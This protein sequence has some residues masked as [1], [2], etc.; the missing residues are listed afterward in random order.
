MAASN[1]IDIVHFGIHIGYSSLITRACRHGYLFQLQ[2]LLMTT[3]N[4]TILDEGG[5]ESI[6]HMAFGVACQHKQKEIVHWLINKYTSIDWE[7]KIIRFIGSLSLDTETELIYFVLDICDD[8]VMLPEKF[9]VT[10]VNILFKSYYTYKS[11]HRLAFM[12]IL[13]NMNNNVA[14]AINHTQSLNHNSN[15]DFIVYKALFNRVIV[16]DFNLLEKVCSEVKNTKFMGALE[17]LYELIYHVTHNNDFLE[18][19]DHKL[20]RNSIRDNNKLVAEWLTH[21]ISKYDIITENRQAVDFGRFVPPNLHLITTPAY[22]LLGLNRETVVTGYSI[23]NVK[24]HLNGKLYCNMYSIDFKN[25]I[26]K[27]T[28]ETCIICYDKNEEL[29]TS[30]GHSYCVDCLQ[31]WINQKN[32]SNACPYCKQNMDYF[33]KVV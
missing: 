21:K 32:K 25:E 10:V 31:T 12:Y 19:Y 8:N 16:I 3:P 27:E 13:E 26:K 2:S 18:F 15:L 33:V 30:C 17:H 1:V 5:I 23:N 22:I 24:Y 6:I 11:N 14:N 20:F 4:D 28:K 9:S 29:N 7:C